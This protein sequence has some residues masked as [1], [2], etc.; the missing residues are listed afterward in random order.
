MRPNPEGGELDPTVDARRRCKK[1]SLSI[2]R[3]KEGCDR[4]S[5]VG[6]V[7]SGR[8]GKHDF[9]MRRPKKSGKKEICVRFC[10]QCNS[11]PFV[12]AWQR[13][14]LTDRVF[15][16]KGVLLAGLGKRVFQFITG[17]SNMTGDPLEA[18]DTLEDRES[19]GSIHPRRTLLKKRRGCGKND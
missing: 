14:W 8:D 7:H 17:E 2:K 6:T 19:E 5:K 3:T 16:W 4:G 15:Q 18:S 12:L 1:N 11:K 13:L 9:L 10:L